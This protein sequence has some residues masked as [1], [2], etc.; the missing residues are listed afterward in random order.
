[1]HQNEAPEVTCNLVRW[2]A[3]HTNVKNITKSIKRETPF[4]VLFREIV[5]CNPNHPAITENVLRYWTASC[6]KEKT[7]L[8]DYYTILL[9]TF[10]NY[11]KMACATLKRSFE[12]DP[13]LSPQHQPSPKRRRCIPMST[14]TTCQS[15][16]PSSKESPFTD[17]TPRITQ[18]M[19]FRLLL[20]WING[21]ARNHGVTKNAFCWSEIF[22]WSCFSLSKV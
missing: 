16:S 1:M 4:W 22:S 5:P 19:F 17:V 6:L 14:S 2:L 7:Y 21:R 13:L 20:M 8:G 3:G 9:P 12:F 15:P 18:G 11:Q 10:L